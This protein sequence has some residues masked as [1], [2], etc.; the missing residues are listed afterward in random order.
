MLA[1]S[2]VPV[3]ATPAGASTEEESTFTVAYLN[4][5]DSFNPFLGIE[6][7]SFEI[8]SS[9]APRASW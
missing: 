7:S 1:A 8:R 2:L 6:A 5:V 3:G 4:E 9:R